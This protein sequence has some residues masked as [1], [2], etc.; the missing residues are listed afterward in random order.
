MKTLNIKNYLKFYLIFLASFAIFYLFF[1]HSVLND[2]S[3]S[4]WLINYKGGFTRRGL[5]G[6]ILFNLSNIFD[7]KL[8]FSIFITQAFFHILYLYLIY[9]YFR[10]IRMNIIH[11]FALFTPIFLLYPVSEIEVLGRK[12][13]ILFCFFISLMFFSEKTFSK[14]YLN[15]STFFM[16]PLVCLVWEQVILFAPYIL[17]L[18][19]FK[20]NFKNFRETFV[21]TS[22][23][24]IPTILTIIFIFL[25][26]LSKEGHELMCDTLINTFDEQCYMS[27]ILL[28]KNTVYFDTFYIHQNANLINYLRYLGIFVI[29]FLP[30]HYLIYKSEFIFKN[31][32]ITK[33]F[34]L[35][36]LFILLYLPSIILFTFGW[37]W[38]RWINIL[39]TYSFLLYIFLYKNNYIKFNNKNSNKLVILLNQKKYLLIVFF[40]VF[41]FGWHPKATL[42]EDIGSLPGYRIP[43]KAIKFINILKIR[44]DE[45]KY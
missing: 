9:L 27:A 14:N 21:S 2:S 34:N 11:I 19:I 15:F 20:N 33:N 45:N 42:S 16:L 39:Y 22:V 3:I 37:D 13:I 23:I 36:T 7:L 6:E 44:I 4:E 5:G 28:I 31:N 26:P 12:E 38:G 18:I 17:V 40:T 29:G 43:Y 30:L 41:A 1:K 10:N 35:N 24:F 8:R 32:F 25:T